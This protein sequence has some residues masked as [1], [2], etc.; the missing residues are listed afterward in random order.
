MGFAALI[1]VP[2]EAR[3][4]DT[5]PVGVAEGRMYPD[6]FLPTLDGG[7]GRLSDYRGKKILLFHFA[8]W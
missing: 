7:L 4:Q 3:A 6:F 2:L 1:C 5:P 8:S